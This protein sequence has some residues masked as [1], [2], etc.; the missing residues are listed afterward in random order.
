MGHATA[1][2]SG[3]LEKTVLLADER[4]YAAKAGKKKLKEGMEQSWRD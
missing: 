2:E 1:T 4:M 3:Q